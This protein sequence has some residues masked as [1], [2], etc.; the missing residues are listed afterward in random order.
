MFVDVRVDI[1]LLFDVNTNQSSYIFFFFISHFQ[2]LT[3][4]E[5]ET[6]RVKI[7]STVM[8]PL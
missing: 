6:S 7:R 2:V 4:T 3:H 5:L 1:K 8:G